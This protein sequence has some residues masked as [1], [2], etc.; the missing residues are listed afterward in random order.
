MLRD[1]AWPTQAT[2]F[3]SA[4]AVENHPIADLVSFSDF[5]SG[6]EAEKNWFGKLAA[7]LLKLLGSPVELLAM[8]G[9]SSSRQ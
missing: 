1:A 2:E 8:I 6:P 5:G 3:V 7:H 4:I 9:Q